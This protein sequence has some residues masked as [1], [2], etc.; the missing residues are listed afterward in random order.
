[1]DGFLNIHK[2]AGWTS[3]DVV[4]KVRNLLKV[5]KVGHA[6][7]LD[8][9]ATGVLPICLGKATKLAEFLLHTDKK[10]RVV[11]K[12]GVATDT[13][14]AHGQVLRRAE[15][16]GITPELV[17]RVLKSFVGRIQQIPPMYSAIKVKGQPLYKMARKGQVIDRLAREVTIYALDVL[18]MREDEVTFDVVCSH[19]TYIRTLC[20]DVGEQLGVG[21]HCLRL[22]RRRC[23]PFRIEDAVT[24]E[25]LEAALV[26]DKHYRMVYSPGVVLG[27]LPELVIRS[28]RAERALHGAPLGQ[29][30]VQGPKETFKKGDL[31]RVVTPDIGL[32]ALA[33]ALMGSLELQPNPTRDPLFKIEKVLVESLKVKGRTYT[34]V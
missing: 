30:D 13:Q 16:N 21:A 15:T 3:H 31:F 8:P 17:E 7:T 1:M 22:E 12:L 25:E 28:E 9:Q 27:H 10:Y 33:R 26:Q 4:A 29:Q 2:A 24:L 18:E 32:V 23:G 14:D 34:T 19:G 5:S 6:G 11:M 20:A